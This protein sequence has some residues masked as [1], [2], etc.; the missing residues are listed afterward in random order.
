MEVIW[1]NRANTLDGALELD[2][3]PVDAPVAL[4]VT[5]KL[6]LRLEDKSGTATVLDSVTHPPYFSI[7]TRFVQGSALR[8]F[9]LALGAAGLATGDY[10]CVLTLFDATHTTGV[11]IH[12]FRA[13]VRDA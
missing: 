11:V 5:N 6:S 1:L 10:D 4:D 3:V 12:E 7:I 2:G 9:S 8:V 13:Q